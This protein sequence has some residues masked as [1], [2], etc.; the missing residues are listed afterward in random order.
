MT[1]SICRTSG[2]V[3][4]LV[5]LCCVIA[6][7][8]AS[9]Y[10]ISERLDHLVTVVTSHYDQFAPTITIRNG[11][12]SISEE[13]PYF[14]GGGPIEG[15]ALVIDTRPEERNNVREYLR[16]VQNGA[17]LAE[18]RILIKNGKQ[19]RTISLKG[20][21]DM[22]L[23]A[24]FLEALA[25]KYRPFAIKTLTAA[26]LIYFFLAKLFQAL[27]FALIPLI[28]ARSPSTMVTYG[29][30]F[31]LA[32]F[33]LIPPIAL[34]V[35][36]DQTT[37]DLTAEWALYVIL[38]VAVLVLAAFDLRKSPEPGAGRHDAPITP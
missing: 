12:A 15:V 17:V 8:A 7:A 37:I 19:T 24:A 33:A 14:I 2:V 30:S 1:R 36:L 25:K 18:D 21:P 10:W 27:I 26:A 4:F 28:V 13:Q 38:Y 6:A 11:R 34:D 31:K 23:N 29:E 22:V 20:I 16:Q 3:T 5:F 32:V 9:I 35:L